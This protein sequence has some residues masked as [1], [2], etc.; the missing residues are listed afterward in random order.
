MKNAKITQKAPYVIDEKV[1]KKYWCTC[2][3]SKNQSYYNA[4]RTKL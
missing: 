2:D 1:G 3:E 4:T